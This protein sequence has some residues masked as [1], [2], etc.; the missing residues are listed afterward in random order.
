[1]SD[2]AMIDEGKICKNCRFCSKR[3]SLISGAISFEC[4]KNPPV[5]YHYEDYEEG[6]SWWPNVRLQD[7]C[8]EFQPSPKTDEVSDNDS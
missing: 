8:G 3:E 1:M 7:W 2:K 5:I 6:A 4:R